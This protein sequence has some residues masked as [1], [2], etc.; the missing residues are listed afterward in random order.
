MAGF[1]ILL[2]FSEGAN[3]LNWAQMG[4]LFGRRSF[5]TLR[6]WQHLPDQLISMWTAVWMGM[7]Y[8][9]TDSY[10]WALFP[11]IGI[12]ALSGLTF[13][14]IPRPRLPARLQ[15]RQAAQAAPPVD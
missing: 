4:E 5:A 1:A 2:A 15:S 3:S 9:A 13:L 11:L 14:A 12:F 7:I 8:D 6:G 10:F